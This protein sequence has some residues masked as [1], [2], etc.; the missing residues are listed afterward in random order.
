MRIERHFT[1]AGKSA[2]DTIEF[3]TAV[4]E[5]KN[6]DGSMVFRNAG[7]AVPARWSQVAADILAQKEL[8]L[9]SGMPPIQPGLGIDGLPALA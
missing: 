3:R 9:S 8:D 4:S 1:T 2:Y 7:F 6:P 5:I